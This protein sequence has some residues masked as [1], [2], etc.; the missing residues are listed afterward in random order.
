[1]TSIARV[2]VTALAL[3]GVMGGAAVLAQEAGSAATQ[4]R[5][6]ESSG[7]VLTGT[8]CRP[9]RSPGPRRCIAPAL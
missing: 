1:M 8:G 6:P 3:S 9:T 5:V 4:T 2:V 7:D